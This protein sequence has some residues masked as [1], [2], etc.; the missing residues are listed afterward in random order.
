MNWKSIE[1][2]VSYVER[3]CFWNIGETTVPAN[4]EV[5]MTDTGSIARL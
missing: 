5:M 1:E 4:V 3:R 2:L